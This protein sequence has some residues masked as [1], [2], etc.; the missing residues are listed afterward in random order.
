[1]L[2]VVLAASALGFIPCPEKFSDQSFSR[3][4]EKFSALNCANELD[5]TLLVDQFLAA[6]SGAQCCWK[7]SLADGSYETGTQGFSDTSFCVP[8]SEEYCGSADHVKAFCAAYDDQC[9]NGEATLEYTA[10]DTAELSGNQIAGIVIGSILLFVALA[11]VSRD[12]KRGIALL[13]I[14]YYI[15]IIIGLALLYDSNFGTPY[16][17]GSDA[18]SIFRVQAA[19]VIVIVIAG[20]H[21][22]LGGSDGIKRE[23]YFKDDNLQL[24][25]TI[26]DLSII[27]SLV[28]A[29]V[30]VAHPA[31]K[32][33]GLFPREDDQCY[34]GA[35]YLYFCG[36]SGFPLA[37]AAL[38]LSAVG[39]L[40]C[41]Y[42]RM[43]ENR[44]YGG[45]GYSL[46]G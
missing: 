3:K 27:A 45:D 37:V 35:E 23:R 39:N 7:S 19:G 34:R 1:M 28:L 43:K 15:P 2:P 4:T 10:L 41:I 46:M 12:K 14:L 11:Y 31:D 40:F 38:I 33:L 32:D 25:N 13:Y 8:A 21:L 22:I 5:N 44:E 9:T 26:A 6:R 36:A 24:S 16:K 18:D 42:G 30:A 20:A 29:I 17:L